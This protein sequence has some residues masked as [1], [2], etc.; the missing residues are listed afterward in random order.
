MSNTVRT[1]LQGGVELPKIGLGTYRLN[2]ENGAGAIDAAIS[3]GYRLI[4]SAFNYDNEGAV[5]EAV[6]NTEVPREDLIITSKL[7]GRYHAYDRAKEAIEE[8]LFRLGLDQIDLYLI[9]WPLPRVD[10]YVEAWRALVDAQERGIIRWIGVSNFLPEHIERLESETGVLPAVNQLQLHPY[11]PD[12]EAVEYNTSR[13]IITEA[14]SPLGRGKDLLDEPV[15]IEI[16]DNHFATPA[17]VVL[18]W[19]MARGV[20]PIPKSSSLERQIANFNAQSLEL[21]ADEVTAITDL[22]VNGHR[23]LDIDPATHEEF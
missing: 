1:E 8:S 12:T 13:G 11:F 17:Q 18:A 7:P 23:V 6:R 16:A 4:D 14:W 21:A 2:G 10:K 3:A 20:V 5:G 15:I 9:H 22:G 19:H